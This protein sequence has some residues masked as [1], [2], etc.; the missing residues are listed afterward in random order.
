M[1]LSIA[2]GT[3]IQ[4]LDLR[5]E[6]LAQGPKLRP[7][8]V[9]ESV[10]VIEMESRLNG[11]NVDALIAPLQSMLKEQRGFVILSFFSFRSTN[12]WFNRRMGRQPANV[13]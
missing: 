5:K 3:E 9:D 12:R 7:S 8:T 2:L 10:P 11:L 13:K 1:L 6:E 4:E